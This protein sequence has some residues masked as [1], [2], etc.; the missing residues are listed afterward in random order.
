ML[1]RLRGTL[2]FANVTS[3][4]ALVFAM[5]GGAY[6]I[7]SIPG[8]GGLIHGCYQK[9]KGSL[10]VIAADKRCRKSEKAITW[11][12]IGPQG[13]PGLQGQ[14]GLQG[15]Q[16]QKGDTGATGPATGPAGGDLAGNYPNPTIATGA[17]TSS[18]LATGASA[19]NLG[20]AGGNL[21]GTYPNPTIATGAITNA[22]IG[23]IPQARVEFLSSQPTNDSTSAALLFDVA[24]Y[25]ND[26]FFS[27]GDHS[28]L[29]APLAGVYAITA[30][31]EWGSNP[32][33]YRLVSICKN[34][35]NCLTSTLSSGDLAKSEIPAVNGNVTT[36]SVSTET[37]LSAGD[38]VGVQVFQTSGGALNVI[39]GPFTN[40]TMTWIGNG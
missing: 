14:Q 21:T 7:T 17:V 15:A 32:T 36:H 10:R 27:G 40:L 12:Q 1:E 16:G 38:F 28:K 9:H 35:S 30:S 11:N 31:V 13:L 2:K 18:K 24:R 8:G 33:G 19:A 22:N 25:D 26:G 39:A 23:L 4:L 29:T 34:A 6:A 37:K 3:V 20:S 5:G